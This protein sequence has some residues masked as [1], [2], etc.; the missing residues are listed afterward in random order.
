MIFVPDA[1]RDEME[2]NVREWIKPSQSSL[3]QFD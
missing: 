2:N 3:A 1:I